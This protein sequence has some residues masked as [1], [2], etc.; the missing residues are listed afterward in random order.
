MPDGVAV[1]ASSELTQ[2]GA[3]LGTPA[4]MAPE[5]LVRADTLTDQWS[6]CA[7]FYEALAGVRPFPADDTRSAAIAAG[8]LA[9]PRQSVPSWVRP[10]LARGLLADPQARWPS[11]DALVT[12][13]VRRRNRR[14]NIL[15]GAA[16]V[17]VVAAAIA[18]AVPFVRADPR[19]PEG[20]RVPVWVD[21]R[22]GCK[23][24]YSACDGRC[25]SVC[26]APGYKI[27]EKVPGVNTAGTQEVIVGASG[28]GNTL[29]YLTGAGCKVDHLMIAHKRGS[30]YVP[31]DLTP[32]IDR[33]RF[34]IGE[35]C[36]TLASDGKSIVLATAGHAGFVEVQIDAHDR[37]AVEGTPLAV[38]PRSPEV[39]GA[40]DVAYPRLTS[41]R[42]ALYYR[43]VQMVDGDYG[44]L[45]GIY[46]VDLAGAAAGHPRR[47]PGARP[48]SYVTGVSSDNLS[49]FVT[50]SFGTNVLVRKTTA[51]PF[52]GFDASMPPAP[53]VGF[54]NIPTADCQLM[55]TT[56]SPGGCRQEDI[57][58]VV[59]DVR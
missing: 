18:I 10:L 46:V 57:A 36:C 38:L 24:P 33:T 19:A 50:M 32:Q 8:K 37:L 35:Y 5:Q 48:Y 1:S 43:L 4:Y 13:T 52:G 49:L 53:I 39:L 56:V 31:V 17:G 3:L 25:V 11:M 14:R 55:F 22:P 51:D 54:R 26:N 21:T 28:D 40:Y 59:P 16:A 44:P 15:M 20:P 7:T 27:G 58:Y 29:L 9:T 47:I 42:S 41:D 45:D 6:Y 23:C 34:D 30:T 2:T 12:A